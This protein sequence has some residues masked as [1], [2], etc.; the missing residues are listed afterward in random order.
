MPKKTE[1]AITGL[2][3]LV[4]KMVGGGAGNGTIT[5]DA[6]QVA[7]KDIAANLPEETSSKLPGHRTL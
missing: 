2:D 4:A 7:L 6:I 5:E 3:A 1:N